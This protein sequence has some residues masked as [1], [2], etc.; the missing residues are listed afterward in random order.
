[1]SKILLFLSGRATM[2]L[3]RFKRE[4]VVKKGMRKIKRRLR[5]KKKIE[6]NAAFLANRTLLT[7][8]SY[9]LIVGTSLMF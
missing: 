3:T 9:P 4:N 8:P 7:I 5:E 2:L 1:M 6:T